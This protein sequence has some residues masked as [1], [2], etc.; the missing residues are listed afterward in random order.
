[1]GVDHSQSALRHQHSWS[2]LFRVPAYIRIGR[3]NKT[4]TASPPITTNTVGLAN[5]LS[6]TIFQFTIWGTAVSLRQQHSWFCQRSTSTKS[7]VLFHIMVIADRFN[8]YGNNI[9]TGMTPRESAVST[10]IGSIAIDN[11]FIRK[12][13]LSC[14]QNWNDVR[15]SIFDFNKW[16]IRIW[17]DFSTQ[18]AVRSIACTFYEQF[19]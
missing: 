10:T 9:I 5:D 13:Y 18:M 11:I 16:D 8:H 6:A 17:S 12:A 15:S 19:V 7:Y 3:L 14:S 4:G 1:M 2:Y